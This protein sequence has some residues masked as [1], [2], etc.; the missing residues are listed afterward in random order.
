MPTN[1]NSPALCIVWL[2]NSTWVQLNKYET[3]PNFIQL[4]Q[5]LTSEYLLIQP[6]LPIFTSSCKIWSK[7]C[8]VLICKTIIWS[9]H[10]KTGKNTEI[11]IQSDVKFWF[12]WIKHGAVSYSLSFRKEESIL[13]NCFEKKNSTLFFS[14][15]FL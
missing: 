12:N 9:H 8:F 11:K 3:A 6:N 10:S 14:W 2:M 15:N 1:V 7:H 4:N 5:N 13:L